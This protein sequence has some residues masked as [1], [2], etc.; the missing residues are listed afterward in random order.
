[1]IVG[2]II[3]A[4]LLALVSLVLLADACQPMSNL[5][6]CDT[7]EPCSGQPGRQS[8]QKTLYEG[9][10]FETIAPQLAPEDRDGFLLMWASIREDFDVDPR[11]AVLHADLLISDLM[12]D[13]QASTPTPFADPL[14]DATYQSAHHIAIQARLGDTPIRKLKRA[15]D[16]FGVLLDELLG[17]VSGIR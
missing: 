13:S 11:A 3:A 7:G 5:H 6:V 16:L 9:F 15:M 2:S 8:I 1:M 4:A 17:S 10:S 12:E 14:L